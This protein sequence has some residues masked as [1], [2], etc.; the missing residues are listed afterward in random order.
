MADRSESYTELSPDE[1][2]DLAQKLRAIGVKRFTGFGLSLVLST[3]PTASGVP[4]ASASSLIDEALDIEK[5]QAQPS[6]KQRG[7]YE[8]IFN[9]KPPLMPG[10]E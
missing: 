5:R 9:G 7:M 4:R 3:L 2:V 6:S 8:Q 10:M 1:I